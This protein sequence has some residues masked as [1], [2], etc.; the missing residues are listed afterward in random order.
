MSNVLSDLFSRM[1]KKK[2]SNLQKDYE[3]FFQDG[4]VEGILLST[5]KIHVVD[6][7]RRIINDM[8]ELPQIKPM[9]YFAIIYS[10]DVTIANKIIFIYKTPNG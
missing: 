8:N 6:N 2:E 10:S 3:K 9:G 4:I 1:F 5:A 7:L